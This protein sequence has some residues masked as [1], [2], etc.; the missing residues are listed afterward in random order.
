MQEMS[1]QDFYWDIKKQKWYG[2]APEA[3]LIRNMQEFIRTFLS[4]WMQNAWMIIWKLW[5][6]K[7]M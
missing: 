3:I 2:M 4:W 5:Q 1:W 6:T 7:W